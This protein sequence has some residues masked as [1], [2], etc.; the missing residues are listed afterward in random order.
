MHPPDSKVI[1]RA[2][3][4]QQALGASDDDTVPEAIA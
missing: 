1:G 2:D 4:H 3:D